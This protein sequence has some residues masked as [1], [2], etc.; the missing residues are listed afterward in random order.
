MTHCPVAKPQSSNNPFWNLRHLCRF[1]CSTSVIT[2][3]FTL[4]KKYF[5]V[6]KMISTRRNHWQE[7][8]KDME[9]GERTTPS[10]SQ[11]ANMNLFG[12]DLNRASS[13]HCCHCYC[14]PAS[15]RVF[16][17]PI[18]PLCHLSGFAAGSP[19][20]TTGRANATIPLLMSP[21]RT[22]CTF[23]TNEGWMK[24]FSRSCKPPFLSKW[25]CFLSLCF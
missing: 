18:P 11:I 7:E 12:E 6:S 4:R 3:F 9:K 14:L 24:N 23:E 17:S 21:D 22:N 25:Y 13:F 1:H 19:C 2:F 8:R 10:L 16:F 5:I 15:L 20:L